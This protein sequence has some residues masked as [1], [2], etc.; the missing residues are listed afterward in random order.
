M[1]L[2]CNTV[3]RARPVKM[4]DFSKPTI[5]VNGFGVAK[6]APL[7]VEANLKR[8]LYTDAGATVTDVTEGD[9]SSRLVCFSMAGAGSTDLGFPVGKLHQLVTNQLDLT[10]LND[11]NAAT[12]AATHTHTHARTHTR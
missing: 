3:L 11:T 5:V 4:K 9:I 2:H 1:V 7:H 6:S 8:L 10:I 12:R